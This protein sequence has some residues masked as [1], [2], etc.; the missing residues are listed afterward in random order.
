[1]I[2][3][4]QVLFHRARWMPPCHRVIVSV[5]ATMEQLCGAVLLLQP[6]DPR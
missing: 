3:D 5:V 4:D 1:M 2:A 6:E